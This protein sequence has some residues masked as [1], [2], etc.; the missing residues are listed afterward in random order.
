MPASGRSETR[1]HGG[2][3]RRSERS[4]STSQPATASRVGAIPTTFCATSQPLVAAAGGPSL[5]CHANTPYQS[6]HMSV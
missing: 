5:R 4:S 2:S 3:R 6:P 1:S